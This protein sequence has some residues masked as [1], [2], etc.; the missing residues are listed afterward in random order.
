MKLRW[1][2]LALLGNALKAVAFEEDM[3]DSV[4]GY[5]TDEIA[6]NQDLGGMDMDSDMGDV[7]LY[8]ASNDADELIHHLPGMEDF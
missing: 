5:S 2:F 6:E 3:V 1:L 4:V 7:N 8:D